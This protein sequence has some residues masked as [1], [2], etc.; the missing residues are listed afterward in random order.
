MIFTSHQTYYQLVV[1]QRKS[2]GNDFCYP[3]NLLP[4]VLQR[5]KKEFKK[6]FL[7]PI[8]LITS[9]CAN[10]QLT[11]LFLKFFQHQNQES[12]LMLSFWAL[13]PLKLFVNNNLSKPEMKIFSYWKYFWQVMW[14]LNAKWCKFLRF[15][16]FQ[17]K[18][19]I[20]DFNWSVILMRPLAGS[21]G[22]HY[23]NTSFNAKVILR[24]EFQ[25]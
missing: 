21:E 19:F 6:W 4:V 2:K 8:K 7:L 10:P 13:L 14:F 22:R 20:S 24:R 12:N 17:S 16:E 3:S 23:N 1:L 11:A 9:G 15:L 25:K 18:N 5:K